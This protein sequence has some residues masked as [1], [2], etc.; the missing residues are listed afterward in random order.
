MAEPPAKARVTIRDVAAEAGVSK[1]LVSLVY[2]SPSQ[3]SERNR[4]LVLDTGRRLGFRPNWA[5]RSLA[6]ADGGFV[7]ILMADLHSPAFA[8]I[9]DGA[10]SR[11][12]AAGHVALMTSASAH[13]RVER[14]ALDPDAVTFFGDLRPSALLVVGE[15]DDMSAVHP[16]ISSVPTVLAGASFDTESVRA[17]VRTDNHAGMHSVVE[18]LASSG[19]RRIAHIGGAGGHVAELRAQAYRDAMHAHGLGVETIVEAADFTHASGVAATRRLL[20]TEPDVTAIVAVSDHTA[21]GALGAL[22]SCARDGVAVVGYGDIE[23]AAFDYIDLSTVRPDNNTIGTRAADELLDA[24]TSAR[25]E[26]HEVLIPTELIVRGTS[27]WRS[28]SPR[29]TS[30]R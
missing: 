13:P 7:G 8:E 21:I 23:V 1:S 19:H 6:A 2:S 10:R 15:V 30:E 25:T 9:I 12:K 11:L 16:L 24:M 3:V 18:H 28:P 22:S 20:E 26:T 4:R 27:R 14:A 29:Q 17:V 5:A